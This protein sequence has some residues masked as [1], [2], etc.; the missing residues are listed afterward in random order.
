MTEKINQKYSHLTHEEREI[1]SHYA[2]YASQDTDYLR[3][4]LNE[5]KNKAMQLLEDF[6]DNETN[7]ILIE[8]VDR[9]RSSINSLDENSI[10]DSSIVKFLTV[11]K[12]I[13]ELSK[14]EDANV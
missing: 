7:K 2:F 9:V 11:T 13:N 8:K 6:E 5:K 10:D 14:K 4:F 3:S 1:I 12:L